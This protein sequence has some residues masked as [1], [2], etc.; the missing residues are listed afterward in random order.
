MR[1]VVELEGHR[2]V[3]ILVSEDHDTRTSAYDASFSPFLGISVNGSI[4]LLPGGDPFGDGLQAAVE[5]GWETSPTSTSD[6]VLN[7]FGGVA[8]I[9][10]PGS[11]VVAAAA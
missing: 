5:G 4:V 10:T 7:F 6:F 9:D 1:T 11:V 3:E 2:I 8:P